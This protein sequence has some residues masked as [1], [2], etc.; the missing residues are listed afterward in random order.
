MQVLWLD[1]LAAGHFLELL[2]ST[3]HAIAAHD[4]LNRLGQHLPRRIQVILQRLAVQ[5]EFAQSNIQGMVGQD[6]VPKCHTHVAQ[7]GAVGQVALP[8]RDRQFF[9]QVFQQGVG[10]SQVPLGIL[11]VNRI[12]LMRHGGRTHFTGLQTLLEVTDADVT[13]DVT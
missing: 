10:Q 3:L 5:F 12:D 9:A 6:G 4:G 11:K 2:V 1:D 8:A 7:D 13:P